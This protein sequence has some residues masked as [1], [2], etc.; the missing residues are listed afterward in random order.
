M[1]KG[2]F[3]IVSAVL[4]LITIT[5][6]SQNK[7]EIKAPQPASTQSGCIQ[8]PSGLVAWCPLDET[9]VKDIQ[10][11][12]HSSPKPGPA[13]PQELSLKELLSRGEVTDLLHGFSV[14]L[15]QGWAL[16]V[17]DNFIRI[18]DDRIL[19]FVVFRVARYNGNLHQVAQSWWLERQAM[20]SGYSQPR[21]AFRKLSQGILIVGEGLG[22][23]FVLHPMMSVNFG[24]LGQTPPSNYREVTAILPGKATALV[25]TLLFPAG[26]EKAKLD[27]MLN[28][29]RSFRFLPQ[30]KMVNWRQETIYDPEVG[31]E[32]GWIHV[33]KG[34]E[35]HGAII[36]QGTKRVPAL[37]LRKGDMMMRVD[38]I[39]LQSSALQTGFGANATTL[40][41]INGQT[42]QQ[43][44]PIFLQSTRDVASFVLSIWQAETG[45]QWELKEQL[46]LPRSAMEQ[47]MEQQIL[48]ELAQSSAVFRRAVQGGLVK[49]AL[50][51][52]SG[53]LVRQAFVSGSLT[54]SQQPDPFAASQDCFVSI[55]VQMFQFPENRSEEARGIF[56]GINNSIQFSPRHALSALERFI[57]DNQE[58]NRMVM[59]M[60]NEEREFNSHMA[61]AWTNALSDQTYV[62]DPETG[63]IFRVH[64]RVWETGEFWRDP[65]WDNILGG[66]ER[67]SELERLLREEG[68][69]PLQQSLEGFPEQW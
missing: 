34:F 57:R 9:S 44:Q 46:E 27:E 59:Q 55:T 16:K 1:L 12:L 3:T 22:Y 43:P 54:L 30:E 35:F 2:K 17:H 15:P 50:S 56:A 11:V 49:L 18:S 68:W 63:E 40:L 41:T 45:E 7:S 61:R 58:L 36:Q 25:V 33:P 10:G 48:Q 52:Q 29:V 66:V 23:P 20:M 32:A 39:D 62:K 31:M 14:R 69:R 28:I 6:F 8:P 53:S 26:T 64:K 37:F 60:L 4:F 5:G 67:G 19:C 42:S 21:F 24:L 65:V 51:A 47:L 38:N 13:G